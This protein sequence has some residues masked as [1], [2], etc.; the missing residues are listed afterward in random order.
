MQQYPEVIGRRTECVHQLVVA[1]L[2]VGSSV[3]YWVAVGGRV[4]EWT[5]SLALVIAAAAV[6]APGRAGRVR[7]A[8]A[9]GAAHLLDHLH[10]STQLCQQQQ[11]VSIYLFSLKSVSKLRR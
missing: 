11:T 3:G 10:L 7:R 5:R 8:A 1:L 4:T 2:P 6:V 9:A